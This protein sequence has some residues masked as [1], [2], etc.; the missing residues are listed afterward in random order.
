M[1]ES[2]ITLKTFPPLDI[3]YEHVDINDTPMSLLTGNRG[4]FTRLVKHPMSLLFLGLGITL[5]TPDERNQGS[6]RS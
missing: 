4:Y 5:Q 3:P 1:V 6:G 2:L